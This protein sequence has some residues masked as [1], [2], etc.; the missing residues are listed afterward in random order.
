[1]DVIRLEMPLEDPLTAYFGRAVE[2]LGLSFAA[3]FPEML[4]GDLL[5]VQSLD[6]IEIDPSAIHVASEHGERIISAVLAS[7]ERALSSMST[8]TVESATSALSS[9]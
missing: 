3:I 9:P 4:P 8:R 1:V 2:E 6:R 7:R 5:C